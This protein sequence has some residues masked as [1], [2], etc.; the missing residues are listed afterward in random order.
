[1]CRHLAARSKLAVPEEAFTAGLV[2]D[3]GKVVL[4]N[5]F[6]EVF[7]SLC[8]VIAA[9]GIT[10]YA[11]EKTADTY[12]HNLIGANLS[13]RWM[14]PEAL[15]HAVRYHQGGTGQNLVSVLTGL[16]IVSDAIV[17]VM[18][19]Q[20]GHRLGPDTLPDAVRNPIMETLKDSATWFPEVKQEIVAA[21]E[22]FNKG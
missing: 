9:D 5:H 8:D 22:F 7:I 16:V 6:P 2:H 21:C 11:A 18:N 17:N 3:I 20:P 1:M 4:V 12:P 15:D 10:F 13:R 19:S 14:L